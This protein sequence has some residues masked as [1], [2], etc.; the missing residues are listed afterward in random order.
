MVQT[1]E[2]IKTEQKIELHIDCKK[3]TGKHKTKI[4]KMG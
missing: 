1:E 3:Q 2:Q 4:I